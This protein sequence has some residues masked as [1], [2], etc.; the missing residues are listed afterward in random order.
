MLRVQNSELNATHHATLTAKQQKE[1]ELAAKI[2]QEVAERSKERA[3]LEQKIA[4]VI[5][6]KEKLIAQNNEN[7]SE[8]DLL[9]SQLRERTADLEGLQKSSSQELLE[10]TAEVSALKA[11][12]EEL[13]QERE[14]MLGRLYLFNSFRL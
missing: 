11:K 12:V 5:Q 9:A 2:E 1:Q 13:E 8:I 7:Q 3:E 6:E 14:V 4:T 10:K